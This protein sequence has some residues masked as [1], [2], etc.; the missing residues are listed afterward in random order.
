MEQTPK[1]RRWYRYPLRTLFVAVG[2][3]VVW[4]ALA[5][6]ASSLHTLCWSAVLYFTAVCYFY[7][8]WRALKSGDLEAE[9]DILHRSEDPAGFFVNVWLR[10]I[11]S[12]GA[13]VIVFYMALMGI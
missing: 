6:R 11:L 4:A 8:T 9:G 1:P 5:T 13:L 10:F 2:V 12:T 7:T 3:V